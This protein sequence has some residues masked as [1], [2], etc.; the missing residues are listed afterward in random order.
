MLDS[1]SHQEFLPTPLYF[2]AQNRNISS[3]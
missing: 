3:P 1:Q 2:G